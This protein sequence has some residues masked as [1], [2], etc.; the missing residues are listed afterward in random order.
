MTS[1]TPQRSEC[2]APLAPA[3]LI[4]EIRRVKSYYPYRVVWG[5]MGDD[6]KP[7][8]RANVTRRQMHDAG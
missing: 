8:V 3:D 4:A 2:K 5:F 6:G 7:D 1:A